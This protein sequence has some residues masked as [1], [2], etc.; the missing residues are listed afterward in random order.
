MRLLVVED[1]SELA[2][3]IASGLRRHG[4]AVDVALDGAA[5]LE[6][7]QAT[8][9]DALVLDRDLPKIHGDD[10][11][12]QLMASGHQVKILMLT[13]AG[14]V[15]NRVDGLNLG[16]DDYLTKPFAFKE[17]VARVRALVRRNTLLPAPVISRIGL[18]I[19]S[20]RARVVR[21]RVDI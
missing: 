18:T 10:V 4:F 13:A 2:E 6:K 21:D 8:D 20:A 14:E 17:L 16:A 11:C 12:A 15:E 5:A 1:E 3:L 9:Y 7:A 19:D